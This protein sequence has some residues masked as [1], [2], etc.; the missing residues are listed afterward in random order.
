MEHL[1]L[2]PGALGAAGL[3]EEL[4]SELQQYYNVHTLNFSGHGGL[5]VPNEAFT[6]DMFAGDIDNFL[7]QE[8]LTSIH[9]FGYSMGGYVA[10]YYA[11]KQPK[12]VKSI[13]T[14]GTK[15][16]WS[17]ETAN[18]ET[19]FLVPEK[20]EQKVP[21]FANL[22]QK[23]HY[24]QD[25]KTIMRKTAE[26]MHLLGANPALTKTEFQSLMFP[27]QVAVGD[28]DNMVSIAETTNVYNA[29]PNAH[30]LVI[31]NTIHPLESVQ[32]S[33]LAYEIRAFISSL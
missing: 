11:L 32:V 13:F 23:R 18:H 30:L 28:Q 14:L 12:K 5:P 27:I 1:L 2:L 29:L 8:G 21:H 24:P 15:F 10:L 31:P 16:D 20:I 6:M 33:R 19:R 9:I 25:W 22:L 7:K 3:F 26:L 4:K 17:A